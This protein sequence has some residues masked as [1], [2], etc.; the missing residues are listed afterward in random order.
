MNKLK[1]SLAILGTAFAYGSYGIWAK[2]IGSSFDLFF[3]TYMRAIIAWVIILGIVIYLKNWKKI[4][5]SYDFKVL[6]GIAVFGIL[7]QGIY[8]SYLHLGVGLSSILYFF[9]ILFAQ[10]FIGI[11]FYKEKITTIKIIS[12]IFSIFGVILIF[13]NDIESFEIL[14]VIIALI[15]G[16]SIGAQSSLTKLVSK[17]YSSWQISLFSWAG[18]ILTC[19]PISLFLKETQHFQL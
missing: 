11:Y 15:S 6:F 18:V 5:N 7:T 17:K 4:R 16:F 19:L 14:A 3:Q 10:F 13:K 2:L 8:Y 9:S 1:G 12:L